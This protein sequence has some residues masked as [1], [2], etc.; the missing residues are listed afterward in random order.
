MSPTPV[1]PDHSLLQAL[2]MA[3]RTWRCPIPAALVVEHQFARTLVDLQV[4]A[5]LG[6]ATVHPGDP[7]PLAGAP[8][9]DDAP[10]HV[11]TAAITAA[12]REALR[13]R[14]RGGTR[15]VGSPS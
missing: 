2:A 14:R 9:H 5:D 4:L 12:G 8:V 15:T 13:E 10:V 11:V 1:T 3:P 6:L 7:V